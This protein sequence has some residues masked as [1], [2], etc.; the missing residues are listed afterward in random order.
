MT[1]A[2]HESREEIIIK[3]LAALFGLSRNSYDKFK[4][5]VTD[6]EDSL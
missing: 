1:D 4:K 5:S 3:R 6:N 2:G